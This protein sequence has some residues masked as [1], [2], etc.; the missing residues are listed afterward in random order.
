MPEHDNRLVRCVR[1]NP[2]GGAL[3]SVQEQIESF[4]SV[5]GGLLNYLIRLPFCAPCMDFGAP[6]V[7]QG[8]P[9]PL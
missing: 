2:D 6:D 9:P 7:D 4:E 3:V 8:E 1:I 5:S